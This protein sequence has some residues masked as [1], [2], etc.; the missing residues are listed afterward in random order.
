MFPESWSLS[1]SNFVIYLLSI[2]TPKPDLLS[3]HTPKPCVRIN[4][5][6]TM[7]T[8]NLGVQPSVGVCNICFGVDW[9]W[10]ASTDCTSHE[11]MFEIIN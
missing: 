9:Q 5:C 7:E 10:T 3:I 11:A 4:Q 1:N 6:L 8:D 2:H